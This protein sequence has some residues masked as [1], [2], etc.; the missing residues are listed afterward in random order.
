V[1]KHPQPDR[2]YDNWSFSFSPVAKADFEAVLDA[3]QPRGQRLN[4]VGLAEDVAAAKAAIKVFAKLMRRSYIGAS[5]GG[6][7]LQADEV[8]PAPDTLAISLYSLDYDPTRE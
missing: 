7:T 2:E 4:A 5:A 1:S 8:E 3:I 6:H